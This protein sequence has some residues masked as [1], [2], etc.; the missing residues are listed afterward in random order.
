M[1]CLLKLFS[2]MMYLSTQNI[3]IRWHSDNESNYINILKLLYEDSD[4]LSVEI[5][6]HC[7]VMIYKMKCSIC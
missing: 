5:L 6:T 3:A 4:K 1:V 2:S 7:V